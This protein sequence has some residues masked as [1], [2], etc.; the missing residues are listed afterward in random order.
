MRVCV[1][2]LLCACRNSGCVLVKCVRVRDCVFV[3]VCCAV[4]SYR[5]LRV[6]VVLRCGFD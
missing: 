3:F 6:F 5:V 4:A 2:V 1:C